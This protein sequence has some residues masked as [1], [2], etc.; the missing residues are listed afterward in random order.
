MSGESDYEKLKQAK[1]YRELN[2]RNC[3]ALI[4]T[5]HIARL[6]LIDKHFK[7]KDIYGNE[8]ILY[9]TGQQIYV[10]KC[11][12]INQIEV[13]NNSALCF[14][15]IPI[16]WSKNNKNFTGFLNNQKIIYQHSLKVSCGHTIYHTFIEIENRTKAIVRNAKNIKIIKNVKTKQEINTLNRDL[17]KLNLNHFSVITESIQDNTKL[18]FI[19]I[20]DN[21]FFYADAKEVPIENFNNIFTEF[22]ENIE[23]NWNIVK[24]VTIVI[25]SI[26]LIAA[27]IAITAFTKKCIANCI[28]KKQKKLIKKINLI[29]GFLPT[30]NQYQ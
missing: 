7:V 13:I 30:L 12:E 27:V 29:E 25:M 15:D 19:N 21:K 14:Q 22:I 2:I 17:E 1:L 10:P 20:N 24:I 28:G 5:L 9:S 18:K 23:R 3:Y 6:T 16:I 4:N 8:V 11:E 26:P